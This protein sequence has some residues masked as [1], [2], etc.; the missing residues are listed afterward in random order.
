MRKV[1]FLLALLFVMLPSCGQSEPPP[2]T[3]S[4]TATSTL[5][6]KKK[7][8][9]DLRDEAQALESM[10]KFFFANKELLIALRDDLWAMDE[11]SYFFFQIN[12]EEISIS[13]H[14][15]EPDSD[16]YFWPE[17]QLSDLDS[18]FARNVE[19]Y[20][21]ILS[22]DRYCSLGLHHWGGAG[23]NVSDRVVAFES[24]FLDE[25]SNEIVSIV[26]SPK[27][28]DHFVERLEND[29]YISTSHWIF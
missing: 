25:P 10:R 27:R 4:S 3:E 15:F 13:T 14:T 19:L 29:W 2:E 24:G 16:G 28:R 23:E 5:T 11:Y 20:F 17:V 8:A 21:D 22:P 7:S 12:G 18:S 6:K 26:Y 9:V 1:A